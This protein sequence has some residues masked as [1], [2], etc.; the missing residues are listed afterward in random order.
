MKHINLLHQ[1][2]DKV[3]VALMEDER[4]LPSLMQGTMQE[5]YAKVRQ[6]YLLSSEQLDDVLDLW[7]KINSD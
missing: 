6:H 2:T 1:P 3:K 5:F 7:R 4:L